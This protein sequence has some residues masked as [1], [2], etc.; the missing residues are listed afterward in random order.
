M[1]AGA[2]LTHND[3]RL[4]FSDRSKQSGIFMRIKLLVDLG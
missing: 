4:C 3:T 2:I 1:L